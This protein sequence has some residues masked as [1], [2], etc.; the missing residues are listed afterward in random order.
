[1]QTSIDNLCHQ[2]HEAFKLFIGYVINLK[3]DEEPDYMKYKRLFESIYGPE[4]EWPIYMSW[5]KN[6]AQKVMCDKLKS[7]KLYDWVPTRIH[8]GQSTHQWITIYNIHKPIKQ[9]YH[10]NVTYGRLDHHIK[11]GNE[12]G[13]LISSIVCCN[14]HW[15]L[16]MGSGTLYSEQK[17]H[18]SENFLPKEWI[19]EK[20]EQGYYVTAVGG[21]KIGKTLVVMSKGTFCTQQSYKVS[22]YFPM[23]WINMKWK[24]GF[25][26]TSI[27]TSHLRWAIIMSRNTTFKD[28]CIELDFGYP[29]EGIHRRWNSGYRITAC[30][31]NSEQSAFVFSINCV[32]QIDETQETLRTS[33]FPAQHIKDK[34]SKSIY[35]TSISY[36]R[37]MS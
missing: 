10:Y 37:T 33:T 3:F 26:I 35:M 36:G 21:S 2:S 25:F 17:Y 27:T 1:M 8:R 9:R 16:I 15:A 22:Q 31:A 30:V 13:L 23:K 14:G 20:W 32:E 34:W 7:D 28:Q 11:R 4:P 5:Y 6:P 19:V 12:D 29:S 18:S 24:E